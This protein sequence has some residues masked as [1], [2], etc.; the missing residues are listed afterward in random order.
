M[1]DIGELT[2][3]SGDHERDTEERYPV[4]TFSYAC[5]AHVRTVLRRGLAFQSQENVWTGTEY[6]NAA[7][8]MVGSLSILPD[9]KVW[10]LTETELK[11]IKRALEWRAAKR[12]A[13]KTDLMVG[14]DIL[15]EWQQIE[16]EITRVLREVWHSRGLYWM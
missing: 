2:A 6:V 8:A 16:D 13:G 1:T 10:K 4:A 14:P 3:W 7:R 12:K 5:T 11:T 15:A 9:T